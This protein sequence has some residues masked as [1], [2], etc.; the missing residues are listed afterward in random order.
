M[1]NILE[2][3]NQLF[4]DDK[5]IQLKSDK[6]SYQYIGISTT[7]IKGRQF[8]SISYKISDSNSKRVTKELLISVLNYYNENNKFPHTYWYKNKFEFEIKSRPCNKSVAE[9]IIAR[10]IQFN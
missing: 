4:I 10:I 9:N 5:T 2:V 1:E 6:Y 3:I 8:N 7:K